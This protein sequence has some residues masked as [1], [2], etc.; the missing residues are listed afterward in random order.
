MAV[1][2][3][4]RRI[5][6]VLSRHT[7]VA[8]D[9]SAHHRVRHQMLVPEARLRVLADIHGGSI[10]DPDEDDL[11]VLKG[12][13]RLQTHLAPQGAVSLGEDLDECTVAP[14]IGETV[15]PAG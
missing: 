7:P 6:T 13:I 10:A 2:V 8:F 15:E 11:I 5:D 4:M 14:V 9:R 12:G 1:T 3:D